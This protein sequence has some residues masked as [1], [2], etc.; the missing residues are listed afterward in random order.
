MEIIFRVKLIM[1]ALNKYF[2][3][4]MYSR[5]SEMMKINFNINPIK[6]ISFVLL[7][8]K[9][10]LIYNLNDLKKNHLNNYDIIYC[11]NILLF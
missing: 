2:S 8:I 9:K 5:K 6:K 1:K 11:I 10:T 4:N 7:I 3:N